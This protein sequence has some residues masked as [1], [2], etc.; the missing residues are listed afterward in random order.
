LS[1]E[2]KQIVAYLRVRLDEGERIMIRRGENEPDRELWRSRME[3][4][5][6]DIEQGFHLP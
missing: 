4:V 2:A 1:E 6:R 3:E 5:A